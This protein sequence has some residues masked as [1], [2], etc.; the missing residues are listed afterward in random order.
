M[1]I[2]YNFTF[3]SDRKNLYTI[4]KDLSH[5]KKKRFS[6]KSYFTNLM[7]KKSAG[8]IDDYVDHEIYLKIAKDYYRPNGK[9][10]LLEDKIV[11]Q[12]HLK[13]N[14]IPG[15]KLLAKFKDGKLLVETNSYVEPKRIEFKLKKLASIYGSIFI[16]CTDTSGG[17]GIFKVNNDDV[18]NLENLSISK[19]Y[20]VERTLI[21]HEA[22]NRVNPHSINTLRVITFKTGDKV[23]IPNCMFR[24]SKGTSY[25][26]NASAGGI[27]VSYDIDNNRLGDTGY[28]L[29]RNGAKSYK[30]HPVTNFV[31]KDA[32]LPFN[33]EVKA[34]VKEAARSYDQIESI[35]WDIAYTQDG[36][37]IL[38]GN[39]SPHIVMTQITL[40]GLLNSNFYK[41]KFKEYFENVELVKVRE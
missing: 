37:V 22:L 17:E 30:R 9:N 6:T 29:F 32:S 40:Q 36:P 39:D 12:E 23:V 38:E 24:M 16:K 3:D 11:F 26:D 21:Q 31:F 10:F 14:G 7:Y 18:F 8:N 1:S 25:L 20:I 28:Q 33:E 5:L 2:L 13:I 34:L 35:G 41:E 15:T 4:Y 27:F 19:D